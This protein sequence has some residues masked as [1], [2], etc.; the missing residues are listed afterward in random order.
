M[1]RLFTNFACAVLGFGIDAF[2]VCRTIFGIFIA[3]AAYTVTPNLA[4]AICLAFLAKRTAAVDAA[5]VCVLLTVGTMRNAAFVVEAAVEAVTRRRG[6]RILANRRRLVHV[7]IDIEIDFA[8]VR[9]HILGKLD[10]HLIAGCF[11][12]NETKAVGTAADD[13][14]I[15]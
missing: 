9:R 4:F 1:L 10:R 8:V 5:F 12:R 3:V 14:E 7:C 15:G 13:R 11:A 2:I 6:C